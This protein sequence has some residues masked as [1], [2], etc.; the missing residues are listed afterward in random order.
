[1]TATKNQ[2]EFRHHWIHVYF[3]QGRG[4]GGVPK[5]TIEF[6]ENGKEDVERLIR[7]A[8]FALRAACIDAHGRDLM[9]GEES[10]YLLH[11][12][13]GA[14]LEEVSEIKW[15]TRQDNHKVAMLVLTWGL[16]S[17]ALMEVVNGEG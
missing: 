9:P 2:M 14:V 7:R 8:L 4:K 13:E 10:E 11:Q 1:M 12:F 5:V 3:E 6:F 16:P 17:E 15:V